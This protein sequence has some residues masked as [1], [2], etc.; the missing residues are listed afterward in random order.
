MNKQEQMYM[1]IGEIQGALNITLL[2]HA[3]RGCAA[4]HLRVIGHERKA[5]EA[6][7][8]GEPVVKALMELA[9]DLE[10][11]IRNGAG[12]DKALDDMREAGWID[13]IADLE[14]GE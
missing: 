2:T 6:I 9:Y 11:R 10:T 14:M 13:R 3:M 5:N 1:Q 7:E 4:R 8:G 12:L